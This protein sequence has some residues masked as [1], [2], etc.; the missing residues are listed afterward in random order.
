[1]AMGGGA[2]CCAAPLGAPR[3]RELPRAQLRG[4]NSRDLWGELCPTGSHQGTVRPGKSVP[5]EPKCV[6]CG[7]QLARDVRVDTATRG[8][9][10]GDIVASG[11]GVSAHVAL[12]AA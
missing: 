11:V 5:V 2:W 8:A 3:L 1:G 4:S 10:G 9:V 6:A 12:P 7:P